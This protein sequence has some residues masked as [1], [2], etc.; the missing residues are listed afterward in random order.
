LRLSWRP[1]TIYKHLREAFSE[2]LKDDASLLAAALAY[3][4][5]FSFVPLFILV[6]IF[7]NALFRHGFLGSDVA[8]Q[9]E[10]LAGQQMPTAAGELIDQVGTLAASF[11]LT[12]VS[13]LL[14]LLGS[15]GLFVHTK[16]AF[17]IIWR[18]PDNEIPFLDTILSYL[19]SYL[20]IGLVA[21]LLLA[22]SILTA[23]LIPAGMQIERF[24]PVHLELL[25]LLTFVVS[26]IFVTLLFAATYKTLAGVRLLWGEVLPGSALAA[27]LFALG[28]ICIEAYVKFANIGSA[29]GA[30]GSLA[31]FLVWIY[32]S[33]QIF[34]FGAEWIKVQTRIS[35]AEK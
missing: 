26:F 35:E 30:A 15:A 34:I 1:E 6:L 29:Y 20:L 10:N 32:Y 11:R 19:W 4:G 9:A 5:L 33:A 16:K 3:Y 12:L 8:A 24:L 14:L 13:V 18:L 2:W 31:V 27:L 23:L 25:S 21:F 28:N 7:I 22:T 17:H